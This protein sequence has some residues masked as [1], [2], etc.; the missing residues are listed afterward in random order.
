MKF[1]IKIQLGVNF[2]GVGV[3]KMNKEFEVEATSPETA[4]TEAMKQ[5]R[6]G[7]GQEPDSFASWTLGVAMVGAEAKA[8]EGAAGEAGGEQKSEAA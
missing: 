6:A 8:S 5:Y 7:G 2:P 3:R 4:V 1:K